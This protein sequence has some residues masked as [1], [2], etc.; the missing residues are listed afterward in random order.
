MTMIKVEHS[1][2]SSKM[3]GP[4][5]LPFAEMHL[6]MNTLTNLKLDWRRSQSVARPP[7]VDD[8]V[9]REQW[10]LQYILLTGTEDAL[11]DP[12]SICSTLEPLDCSTQDSARSVGSSNSS[13]L[14]ITV[15]F[16][17]SSRERTLSSDLVNKYYA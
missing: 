9:I 12:Q 6:L 14:S 2:R 17:D 10:I 1:A 7:T 16:M 5:T 11:L 8:Y 3:V 4:R 15:R 13:V